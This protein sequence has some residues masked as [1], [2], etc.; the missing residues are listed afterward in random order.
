[1][2]LVDK[3]SEELKSQGIDINMHGTKIKKDRTKLFLVIIGAAIAIPIYSLIFAN[4][5][6]C[7]VYAG[8]LSTSSA[9]SSSSLM[10]SFSLKCGT[11][12]VMY[13]VSAAI[14]IFIILML[15]LKIL[16]TRKM[17]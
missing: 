7:I 9:G 14:L 3:Y 10:G 8:S 5:N 15:I 4:Y 16:R 13:S 1:M 12:S 17:R 11:N 6:A 2:S